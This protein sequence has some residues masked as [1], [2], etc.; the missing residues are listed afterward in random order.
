MISYDIEQVFRLKYWGE[1]STSPLGSLPIPVSPQW[2][3]WDSIWH[4][5]KF[6]VLGCHG[7][8]CSHRDVETLPFNVK[9]F[10][11]SIFG[12][13]LSLDEVMGVGPS[14]WDQCLKTRKRCQGSLCATWGLSREQKAREGHFRTQHGGTHFFQIVRNRYVL[15]KPSSLRL[16]WQPKWWLQRS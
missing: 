13:K 12:R 1:G 6:T 15:F 7:L 14:W 11:G 5:L 8:N 16:L 9:V 2:G 4:R 3:P 10:A